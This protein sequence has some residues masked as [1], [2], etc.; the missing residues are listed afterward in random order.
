MD[1][2]TRINEPVDEQSRIIV[3][4]LF[5]TFEGIFPAFKT[6]YGNQAGFENGKRE[7]MKAICEN[8][9][10]DGDK[11]RL[12]VAECRKMESPFLLSIGKFIS[13]YREIG[14]YDRKYPMQNHN[15][16]EQKKA[17]PEVFKS[18]IDRIKEMLKGIVDKPKT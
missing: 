6:N 11:I 2:I 12:V 14:L 16:L 3:N 9:I 18:N 4:K 1:D 5:L 13:L 7:W 8:K 10:F 17:S 15:L